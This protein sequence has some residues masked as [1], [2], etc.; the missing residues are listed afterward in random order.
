MWLSV[1]RRAQRSFSIVGI[2]GLVMVQALFRLPQGN[3]G[4]ANCEVAF[5]FREAQRPACKISTSRANTCGW[6]VPMGKPF[7]ADCSGLP[8]ST[9]TEPISSQVRTSKV[10]GIDSEV[11]FSDADKLHRCDNLTHQCT[12]QRPL[13]GFGGDLNLGV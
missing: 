1:L 9:L 6:F 7:Y 8:C 5:S 13:P 4:L 11:W 2:F 3:P 12:A 10:H